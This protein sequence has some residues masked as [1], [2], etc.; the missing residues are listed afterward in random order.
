MINSHLISVPS[1]FTEC[2]R[3][4]N[5]IIATYEGSYV[6]FSVRYETKRYPDR[7]S[8]RRAIDEAIAERL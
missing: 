5:A 1:K 3:Y 4:G 8:C 2:E 6:G 7:A